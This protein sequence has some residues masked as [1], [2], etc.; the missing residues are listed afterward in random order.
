MARHAQVTQNNKFAI[1]LQYLKKE[2][3]DEVDFL[4]VDKHESL[5]KID[6]M[7]LMGMAKHSR[8]FQNTKFAM[9][10]QYLTKEFRDE[11][12]FL[13][14]DKHESFL[15]VDCN[16]LGISFLQG[17]AIITDRDDQA[18]SYIS[19]KKLGMEFIFCM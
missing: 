6:T 9:S 5:I 8:S 10:L 11:V 12:D 17:D 7:I 4:R 15:Q 18:F 14:A 3:S 19:K 13:H 1:F 16:S 2:V